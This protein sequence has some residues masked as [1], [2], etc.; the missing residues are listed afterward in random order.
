MSDQAGEGGSCCAGRPPGRVLG[1]WTSQWPI[2]PPGSATARAKS[3]YLPS[4]HKSSL[5]VLGSKRA[6]LP[7]GAGHVQSS[8]KLALCGSRWHQGLTS[9]CEGIRC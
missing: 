2:A 9:P 4:V 5:C 3:T 8:C 1:L 6:P 7:G